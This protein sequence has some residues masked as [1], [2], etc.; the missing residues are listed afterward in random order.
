MNVLL[1]GIDDLNDWIGCLGGHPQALTPNIDRLASS[2]MLFTNAHCQAPICN[3]SRISM[4]T[5][6]LPSSTGVYYLSPRLRECESTR[7][8]VTIP[9]HFQHNGFRTFGAGK[10]FHTEGENEFETYGGRFGGM[11]P[12]PGQNI[13]VS[14]V[15]PLWD[16]GAFPDSDEL[17][18]DAKISSW[19]AD[20]LKQEHD[21]PFFI[22]AGFYRPHV[23]LYAPQKWFDMFPLEEIHLPEHRKDDLQDIPQYAQDLSWSSVAPRHEWIVDNDQWAG[24]VQGY[25]A[26]IA[27]VDAQVG[28]VLDALEESG[29]AEN[30][31]VILFSDHGFHLGTKERWGKRSL[32]EQATRVPLIIRIPGMEHSGKRCSQPVGLIDLFPTLCSLNELELPRGLEG[33]SLTALI[34]DPQ[35]S[36]ERPAL[37]TFGQNNHALR[38][39]DWRYSVY[40]DGSE[41]LYNHSQDP[42]EFNNLAGEPE[43]RDIIEDHRRWLPQTNLPMAPGSANAD[44]RPGSAPD[45]DGEPSFRRR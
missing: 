21:Q 9:A 3:P 35:S 45:I 8:L 6:R 27:F 36:R 19:I 41:E 1:I 10:I 26:S 12:R 11:G 20:V 28:I 40:A 37:T 16:W 7:S 32:W 30:T 38:S 22:G 5:G 33:L 34:A 25:L 2:G 4:L 29:H 18:P 15:H 44:A 31:I 14:H 42:N 13:N 43:Y 23:P 24:A 17:M 39:F